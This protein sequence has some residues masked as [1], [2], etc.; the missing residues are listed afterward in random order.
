MELCCV[1]KRLAAWRVKAHYV[2]GVPGDI[3]GLRFTVEAAPPVISLQQRPSVR[4]RR[5][6]LLQAKRR[7]FRQDWRVKLD[8]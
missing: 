6:Y 7:R 3:T 1:K 4:N 2:L 5:S 8:G